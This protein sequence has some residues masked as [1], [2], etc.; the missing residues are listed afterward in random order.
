MNDILS[1]S[2]E[3]CNRYKIAFCKFISSNDAGTTGAHQQGFYIPKNSW[4]LLFDSPGEKGI[5]KDKLV[6]IRWQDDFE[7]RS[8]FIW[9]GQGTRSEYRIT[10][11]GQGFPFFT[12]EHV[13]SL[14]I[15][16]KVCDSEYVGY[17]LETDDEIEGFVKIYANDDKI[18][19]VH[20]VA[21][22]GSELLQQTVIAMDAG[23]KPEAL[24]EMVFAHPTYSEAI[25]EAFLGLDNSAINLPPVK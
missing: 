16:V 2:I 9:Y 18:L 3:A 24:T 11:F 4:P 21:E 25:H 23:L 7:T 15:L 20:I 1:K 8:R 17:V 22:R 6:V 13:G 12:D 5:N 10:R 14:L 19:G